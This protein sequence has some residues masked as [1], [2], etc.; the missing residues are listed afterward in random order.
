MS[1]ER[2]VVITTAEKK[3]DYW[4]I[5]FPSV[6]FPSF[7]VLLDSVK[8]PEKLLTAVSF[9]I[10]KGKAILVQPEQFSLPVAGRITIQYAALANT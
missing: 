4:L 5:S 7:D 10:R 3:A 9:R 6:I 2:L 8:K 1:P